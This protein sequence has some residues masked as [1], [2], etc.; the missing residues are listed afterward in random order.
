LIV[1]QLSIKKNKG[2][3]ATII[4]IGLH[5][6]IKAIIIPNKTMCG[7]FALLILRLVTN[8]NAEK[9]KKEYTCDIPLLSIE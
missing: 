1:V 3:S 4:L 5:K 2:N 9:R 7:L 6:K 8:A